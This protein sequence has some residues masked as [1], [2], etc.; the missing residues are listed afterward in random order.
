MPDSC[1]SSL[2]TTYSK[3]LYLFAG[4]IYDPVMSLNLGDTGYP[5]LTNLMFSHVHFLVMSSVDRMYIYSN[6]CTGSAT[7]LHGH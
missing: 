7:N 3:V 4:H 2:D 1:G 5:S 6:D